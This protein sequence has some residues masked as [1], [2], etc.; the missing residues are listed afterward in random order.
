M[1]SA[2]NTAGFPR[3]DFSKGY[4]SF[5]GV[6]IT[7]VFN[8]LEVGTLQAIAWNTTRERGPIYTIG[9]TDAVGI[10][11]GKRGIAGSMVFVT[12]DR[13]ELLHAM[14]KTEF[15]A[16]WDA[17]NLSQGKKQVDPGALQTYDSL[18]G[19]RASVL[20]GDQHLRLGQ[21][22]PSGDPTDSIQQRIGTQWRNQ[23]RP[24][25]FDGVKYASKAWYADQLMPFEITLLAANEYGKAMTR[26]IFGVEILNEGG[27]VSIDD[28]VLENQYSFIAR[29]ITPWMP[30]TGGSTLN[31]RHSAAAPTTTK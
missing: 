2:N 4:N 13:N 29:H 25:F 26:K 12:F 15:Y 3:Q 10:A 7:A 24:G 14:N 17:M 20:T 16:D 27:G 6:D 8:G 5:A 23:D 9:H 11:R 18:S 1:A 21:H 30:A 31:Q 22:T 19:R 28:L